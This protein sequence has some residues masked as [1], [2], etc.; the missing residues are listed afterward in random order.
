M[1]GPLE[2]P[3]RHQ[4]QE[5]AHVQAVGRRIEAGV[6]HATTAAANHGRL[7]GIGDLMDQSAPSEILNICR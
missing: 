1:P 7:L 6:D 2:A 5:V 3:Q 4:R